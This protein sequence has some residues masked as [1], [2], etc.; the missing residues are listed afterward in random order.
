MTCT[1]KKYGGQQGGSQGRPWAVGLEGILLV[2]LTRLMCRWLKDEDWGQRSGQQDCPCQGF[3]CWKENQNCPGKTRAGRRAGHGWVLKRLKTHPPGVCL[4]PPQEEAI[5]HLP[6]GLPIFPSRLPQPT[7]WGV[8]GS[9]DEGSTPE[10]SQGPKCRGGCGYQFLGQDC[11]ACL[12]HAQ[13]H[14]LA[15]PR[16]RPEQG[17]WGG[18]SRRG[19]DLSLSFA[20]GLCPM[21][22]PTTE[23]ASGAGGRPGPFRRARSRRRGRRAAPVRRARTPPAC[24]SAPGPQLPAGTTPSPD[25]GCPRV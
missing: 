21:D 9:G 12:I 23:A 6:Q 25:P 17:G 19:P 8:A 18:S 15:R 13:A 10:S 7:A 20:D 5:V 2:W 11:T 22:C 16:Q 1:R 4:L 24:T 14:H 3:E